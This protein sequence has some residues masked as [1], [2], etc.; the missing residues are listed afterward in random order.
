[1]NPA[2]N[3][4]HANGRSVCCVAEVKELRE[5]LKHLVVLCDAETTDEV[6]FYEHEQNVD[7]DTILA[8]AKQLLGE[9]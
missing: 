1:M 9:E 7:L 3:D 4:T 5:A 8:K 6:V 2:G